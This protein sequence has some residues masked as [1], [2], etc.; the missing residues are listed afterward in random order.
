V[1]AKDLLFEELIFKVGDPSSLRE[2]ILNFMDPRKRMVFIKRLKG[3]RLP[4][5][6]PEIWAEKFAKAIRGNHLDRENFPP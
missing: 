1:G 3:E 6:T 4:L 5:A 2:K